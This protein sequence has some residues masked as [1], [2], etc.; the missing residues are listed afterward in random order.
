[1]NSKLSIIFTN[2][3]KSISDC[4]RKEKSMGNELLTKI[5]QKSHMFLKKNSSLLLSLGCSAGVLA[6]GFTSA[7]AALKARQKLLAAEEE[8]HDA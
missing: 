1:M 8:T 5:S 3:K 6:T 4:Y 2:V 7:R